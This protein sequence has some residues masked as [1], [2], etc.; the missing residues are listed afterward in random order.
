MYR[1]M[2]MSAEDAFPHR[3]SLPSERVGEFRAEFFR[4]IGRRG[5][6]EAGTPA[7]GYIGAKS[8]LGDEQYFG[9][10]VEGGKV[11]LS[12]FIFKDTQ[13]GCFFCEGFGSLRRVA[14]SDAK[15]DDKA[16]AD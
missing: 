15:Q 2:H 14:A 9:G 3:Q 5:R 12:V 11:H 13:R 10:C 1:Y 16:A 6:L 8:E 4:L 7:S